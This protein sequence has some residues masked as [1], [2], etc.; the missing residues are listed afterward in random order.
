M[1]Q[2][3]DSPPVTAEDLRRCPA[4]DA[5]F[6]AYVRDVPTRRTNRLIPLYACLDC[7]SF[8][9]PSGYRETDAQLKKDVDW[10]V[11]VEERNRAAS[12]RLFD[13]LEQRGVEI[14][15][16]AE[17]GCGIGTLLNVARERGYRAVGFDV[18]RHAADYAT[19]VGKL[20]VRSEFWSAETAL[21]PIDLFLC[22]SV[23]EHL[24]QPR[25]LIENLCR[26]AL[27]NRAALFISVPF[28]DRP[29][30]EFVLDPEPT[31]QGTP[32]FDNDVHVV[33]FSTPGLLSAM[34]S[35]GLRD[36]EEVR[37]GLWHGLLAKPLR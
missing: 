9:N 29:K 33:H 16:V 24:D 32:F 18:N 4:C 35:F 17:I 27:R 1:N 20:D 14:S 34:E 28:L 22:I 6:T 8:W 37:Y 23:L 21:P 13:H 12:A 31:R 7:R 2:V 25:P 30:W 5:P 26:A 3:C 10:G 36:I 15:S 11:S 19:K